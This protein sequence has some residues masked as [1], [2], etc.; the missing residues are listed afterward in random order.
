MLRRRDG[1]ASH[2][3]RHVTRVAAFTIACDV[4][5]RWVSNVSALAMFAVARSAHRTLGVG[6][7]HVAFLAVDA[8]LTCRK[9][10]FRPQKAL[11]VLPE[12][13]EARAVLATMACAPTIFDI[14]DVLLISVRRAS[15]MPG[16][17][18]AFIAIRVSV[19]LIRE[20]TSSTL[21]ADVCTGALQEAGRIVFIVGRRRTAEISPGCRYLGALFQ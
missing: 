2:V 16:T 21:A 14:V 17:P 6:I 18:M 7:E 9:V 10:T 1:D 5:W 3:S 19:L 4:R 11:I 12:I 13:D 20:D 8:W 15:A